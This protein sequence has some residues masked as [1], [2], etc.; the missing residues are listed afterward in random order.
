MGHG[1]QDNEKGLSIS[2]PFTFAGFCLTAALV[3]FC[4]GFAL[5]DRKLP[6]PAK[7]EGPTEL[8]YHYQVFWLLLIVGAVLVGFGIATNMARKNRRS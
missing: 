5:E 1:D 3:W 7:V 6:D 4:L 2:W 8:K